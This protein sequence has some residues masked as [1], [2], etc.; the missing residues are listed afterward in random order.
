MKNL[1]FLTVYR[2]GRKKRRQALAVKYFKENVEI[3]KGACQLLR[4]E[5]LTLKTKTDFLGIFSYPQIC[6]INQIDQELK[7]CFEALGN[8]LP[9]STDEK[10]SYHLLEK[11]RVLKV[12]QGK[13]LEWQTELEKKLPKNFQPGPIEK[14]FVGSVIH[15][16]YAVL[17][18]FY[19]II[20]FLKLK[21]KK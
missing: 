6:E 15:G 5:I 1:N 16:F 9:I 11:G 3:T 21:R 4:G 14:I 20:F 2:K 8:L 19:K 18:I 12:L 7:N 17:D 10:N 13:I